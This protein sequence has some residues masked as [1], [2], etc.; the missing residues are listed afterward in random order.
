MCPVGRQCAA[1]DRSVTSEG[2]ESS[3][4]SQRRDDANWM[5]GE[6]AGS[7]F[8]VAS[9]GVRLRISLRALIVTISILNPVGLSI[10][11]DVR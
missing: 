6:G 3:R 10:A 2:V 11:E 7:G 9:A 4:P 5:K 8:V 1:V